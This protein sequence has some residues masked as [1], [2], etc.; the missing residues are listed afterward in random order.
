MLSLVIPIY[1]NEPNLDRLLAEVGALRGKLASAMEV[2]FV[3]DGSPDRCLEI[4]RARLPSEAYPS[5]LI[6]LSRNFGAFSAIAAGLEAGSG[7]CFAVL[8]ADLQE[9][10]ELV[11]EFYRLLAGGE[12]DVVFGH[13]MRRSGPW[14]SDGLSKLFWWLYRALVMPE[15]PRGGVDVFGCTRQVRDWLLRCPEAKTN[16]IALL[17]WVGFRRRYAAYERRARTEG[18]SA[19]TLRKKVQYSL[20]SIFNFTDL[21]AQILL[22]AGVSGI[23][24]AVLCGAVLAG[25]KLS[26]WVPVPG[27]SAIILV[28]L[29]FT[30]LTSL[31]LGIIG[32][33]LWLTLQNTRRLPNYI[34]A[35]SEWFREEP[36]AAAMPQEDPHVFGPK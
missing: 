5:R 17:F 7:D 31:G 32:Q 21:P 36:A 10:P 13:R 14:L 35:S 15:M 24:F 26:G 18:R 28:L 27:Y 20:D 11:V 3:I 4:L 30:G 12:A 16:L 6:S 9:P 25:L 29:F 2:V 34:V 23:G 8:S 19:W 33:Y 22:F 1:K